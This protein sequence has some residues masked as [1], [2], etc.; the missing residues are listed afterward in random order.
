MKHRY[1]TIKRYIAAF[2]AVLLSI[3]S[4]SA[5]YPYASVVRASD[6]YAVRPESTNTSFV[7][8]PSRFQ[9]SLGRWYINGVPQSRQLFINASMST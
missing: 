2:L 6:E 9:D 3:Q 1:A 7:S 4:M 8:F 5:I